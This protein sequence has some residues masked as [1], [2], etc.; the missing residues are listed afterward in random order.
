V[1]WPGSPQPL[2]RV[3][4]DDNISWTRTFGFK[5]GQGVVQDHSDVT[6]S[7]GVVYDCSVG[8]GIN[9]RYGNATVNNVVF[10]NIDIESASL[11]LEN[12]SSWEAI[13]TEDADDFGGG[14]VT[15]VTIE[16]INVRDLG[17]TPSQ[18]SGLFNVTVN[19]VLFQN[20]TV[21]GSSTPAT[22][23]EQMNVTDVFFA[24]NIKV[25]S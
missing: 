8:I 9:H 1:N 23:L 6:F 19:G 25:T 17:T 22:T 16:D 24:E 13:F 20:I 7:N 10:S 11:M 3:I 14:P 5:V 4:F 18:L 15:N 2:E 12:R 21:P